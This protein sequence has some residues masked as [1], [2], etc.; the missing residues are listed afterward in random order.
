MIF[1]S[2]PLGNLVSLCMKIINSVV[3]VGLYYGFLITFSIGPSYLPLLRVQVMEEGTKKKVSATTGFIMGQLVV[4]ISIYY[5]PLHLA[6]CRPHTI[7]VLGL[8]YLLFPL[9]LKMK[10]NNHFFDY[11]S[12][13]IRNLM[14][15]LSIQCVFLDNFIFQ[16]F[17]FFILP[18]SGPMSPN[19]HSLGTIYANLPFEL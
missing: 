6:L 12:T 3:V 11:E 16:I 18:S 9:F 4:F 5:A 14:R 7:T 13:T 1:K 8:T 2:F 19:R 10:N 17:N 15:N